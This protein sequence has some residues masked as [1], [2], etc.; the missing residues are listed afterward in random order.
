MKKISI[1][2]AYISLYFSTY[3]KLDGLIEYDILTGRNNH[4]YNYL[5]DPNNIRFK[6]AYAK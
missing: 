2:E 5:L 3:C 1:E 6:E 4:N